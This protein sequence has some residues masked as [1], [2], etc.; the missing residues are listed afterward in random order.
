[1]EPQEFFG[2]N[3]HVHLNY[4]VCE[5]ILLFAR[6]YPSPTHIDL[7]FFQVY[8]QSTNSKTRKGYCTL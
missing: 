2:P 6:F 1:M 8:K 4:C 3:L 5:Y 7:N